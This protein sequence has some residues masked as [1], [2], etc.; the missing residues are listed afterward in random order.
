MKGIILAGGRGSRLY[1]ATFV[2]CKQ[3]LPIYDKPMIYYPLSLLMEANIREILLISTKHDQSHFEKLLKDGSHLGVKISYDIQEEPR[4]IADSFLIAEE[5]IGN[6][7]VALVLGDNIFY[8]HN[9]SQILQSASQNKEGAVIFG[10]EVQN[11][12]RYGVLEFDDDGHIIGIIEKPKVVPSSYAVTGLYFYDSSVIE[13]AKN[14]V[15]SKRGELEI[16]DVNR[17]YLNN[18]ALKCHFFERGFAWLDTGT[19][20]AMQEASAY[21]QTIQKRQGIKVCCIEETAFKM[22]FISEAELLK[23]ANEHSA[24]E[25]GTYL[26]NLLEKATRSSS[27]RFP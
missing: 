17:V 3:L 15:P 16:T 22:N 1:P 27:L 8:G 26:L 10:Y 21:V 13:I 12:E 20:D 19:P 7:A 9:L 4:G 2:T 14:L 23:L 25:Y 24:S 6:D 11:P 18:G 5:F